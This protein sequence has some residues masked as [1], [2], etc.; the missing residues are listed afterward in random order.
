MLYGLA[1]CLI[2]PLTSS[3]DSSVGLLYM[4]AGCIPRY[5]DYD[6]HSPNGGHVEWQKNKSGK[7]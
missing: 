7:R 5:G 4:L 2:H 1:H 6:V 3:L